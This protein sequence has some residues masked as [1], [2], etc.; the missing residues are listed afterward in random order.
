MRG[1]A[2][3]ADV[4]GGEHDQERPQGKRD[5]GI[6]EAHQQR[7]RPREAI[8]NTLVPGVVDA[9]RLKELIADVR[10][11]GWSGG[12]ARREPPGSYPAPGAVRSREPRV[13]LNPPSG[14]V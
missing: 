9:A 14:R 4:D 2:E 3:L 7:V 5:H 13:G 6:G 10:A 11:G 8:G 1:Q 12:P